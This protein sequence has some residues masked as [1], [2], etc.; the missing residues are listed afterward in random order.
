MV[1]KQLLTFFKAPC[2]IASLSEI[3]PL[4]MCIMC[5]LFKL[6]ILF[7]FLKRVMVWNDWMPQCKEIIDNMNDYFSSDSV[8]GAQWLAF[9][10]RGKSFFYFYVF[11]SRMFF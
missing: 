9:V 3:K 4:W 2:S 5:S 8:R 10:K 6:E 1:F 11:G 7:E